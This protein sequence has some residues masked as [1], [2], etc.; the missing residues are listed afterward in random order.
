[1]SAD[2]LQ[3]AGRCVLCIYPAFCAVLLLTALVI[4]PILWINRASIR[5]ALQLVATER[6]PLPRGE[7]AT[8]CRKVGHLRSAGHH[9]PQRDPGREQRDQRL[10]LDR[11]L[12]VELLCPRRGRRGSR[13]LHQSEG[14]F[15]DHHRAPVGGAGRHDHESWCTRNDRPCFADPHGVYALGALSDC[16]GRCSG[17]G[18]ISTAPTVSTSMDSSR[19]RSRT[20]SGGAKSASWHGLEKRAMALKD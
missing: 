5:S 11:A 7:L 6:V 17:S 10:D 19:I 13:H 9:D 1:M 15:S 2:V 12:R 18:R 8:L 4:G 14:R 3:Y 20:T 16:R